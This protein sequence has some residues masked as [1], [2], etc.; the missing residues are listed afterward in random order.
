MLALDASISIHTLRKIREGT[1]P[2]P[3]IDTNAKFWHLIPAAYRRRAFESAPSA[4]TGESN[5]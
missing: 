2:N 1:I 5:D 4:K 3:G